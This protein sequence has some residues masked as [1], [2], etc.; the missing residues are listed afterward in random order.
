VEV[1][2]C[3]SP[4]AGEPNKLETTRPLAGNDRTGCAPHS[5][6]NPINWKHEGAA[7]S[8]SPHRAPHSLGNP[9]NWKLPK[10]RPCGEGLP[11]SPLAGEPNK[12]ETSAPLR[13]ANHR[14][15]SPLAG[16]PNKLE[17]PMWRCPSAGFWFFPHSLGNPINWKRGRTPFLDTNPPSP[18]SL[19]NPINWKRQVDCRVGVVAKLPTR[20]GTQ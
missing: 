3:S 16:E 19:G 20:W 5:L 8:R 9:I 18:H 12:L 13:T 7:V 4:L 2:I 15:H 6:G 17:T 11:S 1:S 14:S 10:P